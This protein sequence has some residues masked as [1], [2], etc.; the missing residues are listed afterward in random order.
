MVRNPILVTIGVAAS[1]TAASE[2]A[3]H[4]LRISGGAPMLW[5]ASAVG[6]AAML[7]F[8]ARAIPGVAL[9]AVICA[10]I[11]GGSIAVV[12][13]GSLLTALQI[14]L[15]GWLLVRVAGF[16]RRLERVQDVLALVLVGA[17]V[18]PLVNAAR[19]V[20][21][22]WWRDMPLTGER[23]DLLQV[24]TLGE[25]VGSLMLVPAILMWVQPAALPRRAEFIGV[26]VATLLVSFVVFSGFLPP[27]MNAGSLPYA[28]FPLTFWAA[29]RLGM[30]GT[31]T[32][33]LIAGSIAVYCHAQQMGPFV[34]V[35]VT[36]DDMF[37]HY[38]SLFLFL[39]VLG[40]TSLLV[41]AAQHQR[42]LAESRVRESETRY[43][44]L[45]EGMNEGVNIT[46]A[47]ARLVF[48]SD[49]F[50]EIT[51]YRR[52]ELIG[53][54][55]QMLTV[56]EMQDVWRESH[57][58]REAGL[59][60]SHPLTMRR[61][62]GSLF[63]VWVSPRPQFGPDGKYT[64]SL[65]VVLDVT[66]RLAAEERAR[67][68]LDQ[69]AHVARVSSM[70]EMASAIAHE[71]NQPLTAIANYASAALRLMKAGRLSDEEA[72]S[73]LARLASEAERAGEIVRKMRGFVRGEEGQLAPVAAASLIAD[74]LKL[75]GAELRHRDVELVAGPADALPPVLVDAIQI[76]QVL[77]NLVRNAAEA[78]DAAGVA[79]RRV[80]VLATRE[81]PRMVRISVRDTGPGIDPE[82]LE[83]IFEPFFTSKPDG[84]GIGLSLSRSIVDAHGGRLWA[85]SAG[86]GGGKDASGSGAGNNASGAGAVFHMTLPIAE[87]REDGRG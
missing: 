85:E 16:D 41:A 82:N 47:D 26:Q 78:I 50:C 11:G 61:K 77:V 69:L 80:T 62:D 5:F 4:W 23:L 64:G 37:A 34:P 29:F 51:G 40:I 54:T 10:L 79:T 8:G 20:A 21:A 33:L 49:R 2:A 52:E 75:A 45:I 43:R 60:E 76:Q 32:A 17:T 28:L 66:D 70:G 35:R 74:V 19:A 84:I 14:A 25:A 63:H 44:A 24:T 55:G 86:S 59:A 38:A 83:R 53:Q 1:Y 71:I 56:P 7:L 36:P 57:R 18:S 22:A 27:M 31:A 9:G 6:L 30:R 87:E 65:N 72:I 13:A 58:K 3:L 48:V 46:D 68:H 81:D 12:L 67:S 42:E 15:G 73:T 39:A